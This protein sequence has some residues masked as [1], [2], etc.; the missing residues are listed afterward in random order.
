VHSSAPVPRSTP[1]P[2]WK[3]CTVMDSSALVSRLDDRA[4]WP[5]STAGNKAGSGKSE[6]QD[7]RLTP[8]AN[9]FRLGNLFA[10]REIAL[11]WLANRLDEGLVKY[12]PSQGIAA[13]WPAR[14]RVLV[15]LTGGPEGEVL[16]QRASR[17]LSRVNGGDLFAVHIRSSGGQAGEPT[18]ALG[19]QR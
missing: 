11:I 14:E 18:Q 5:I 12:L 2:A 1:P 6:S 17:I 7:C 10:L 15:G 13:S 9:E 19:A 16:I 4:K 3:T 8:L